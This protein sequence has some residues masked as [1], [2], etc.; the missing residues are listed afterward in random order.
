MAEKLIEAIRGGELTMV[1]QALREKPKA[2][3]LARAVVM[4]G[5]RA[6]QPAL[7]LLQRHGADLNGVWRGYCAIHN[8]IQERPHAGAKPE[9]ERLRCLEWLLANGA[10]PEQLGA[11]PPA[12][13]IV[14]AAFVGEAEFVKRLRDGGSRMD[15]FAAAALGDRKRV[16]KALA[17]DADCVRRRDHGGL[18]ALQ[19]ACGGRMPRGEYLAIA[20]LLVDA[21]A[22][23]NAR[24]KSWSHEVDATHYAAG[25]KDAA[26]LELL[27]KNGADPDEAL[28]HTVWGKHFELA[29]MALRHGASA[30]RAVHEGRPL[31]N[32]LIRWGQIPATLWMLEHGASPNVADTQGWTA[33]HQAASRG[34]ARMMRAVL[35]AGGDTARR[36]QQGRTPADV[37][38]KK[39]LAMLQT[40]VT[41]AAAR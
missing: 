17:S 12:R 14:V 10:D 8:L 40:D 41:R 35:D 3:V 2:A 1:R 37:A 15:G 18:T 23:V 19:C 31:L 32:N 30:E 25:S 4:A 5:G 38:H 39:L 26:L 34:N 21:G 9:P 27:L 16:E 28:G 29:E 20:R 24:T 13:A 6:W 36:D 33:V 7:E 22:E 11:W